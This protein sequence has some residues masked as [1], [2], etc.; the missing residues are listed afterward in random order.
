MWLNLVSDRL[1]TLE[2]TDY[3]ER[4]LV[5]RFSA[6]DGVA[7]ALVGGG[8]E[9][10]MRIWIDRKALA[11]RNLAIADVEDA[12]RA[13]NVELPAGSVESSR[14]RYTVRVQRDFRT[15]KDFERLV[16]SRGKDGYLV[17]LGDVARVEKS[18]VEDRVL[19]RG[20]GVPMVSIGIIKQNQANTLEVAKGARDLAAKLNPTLPK[21]MSIRQSYDGSIFVQRAIDEVY[22]TLFITIGLVVLVIFLFLGSVRAML[23]PALVVPVSTISATI[24][25][26]VLGFSIN[27][28][29]LLALVLAIGLVVD[30]AIVVLE[31][32][33]RRIALGESPSSPPSWAQGRSASRSSRQPWF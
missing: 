19:F 7:R 30:D 2:L 23:I 15:P 24:M 10:A 32:I 8:Q 13:D 33:C 17:R 5:D 31:N 4:F 22:K 1:N 9:Y 6:L 25:L 21:G 27:M 29:T 16:L 11:A 18:A 20:N 3:A 14:R 28:L 12:L 26:W